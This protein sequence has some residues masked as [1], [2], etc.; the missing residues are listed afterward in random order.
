M[1]GAISGILV[2]ATLSVY[3]SF[4]GIVYETTFFNPNNGPYMVRE[5]QRIKNIEINR[6]ER[7]E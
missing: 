2:K 4:T 7:M 5:I 1:F 6:A 3:I